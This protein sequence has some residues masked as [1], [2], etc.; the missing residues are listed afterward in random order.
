M[1]MF[2][3]KTSKIPI[4]VIGVGTMGQHHA[5]IISQT[6]GVTLS[7]IFDANP[8]RACEISGR[9]NC[10]VFESLNQALECSRAVCVAAPTTTHLE[11]GRECLGR[12]LHVLMEK[13][14]AD[15]VAGAAE[16]ARLGEKHGVTLMAG[17]VERYNPAIMKMMETLADA[18]EEIISIDIRRLA[19]FDGSR[20]MDVDV[21]YDLMIHDIDLALDLAK[22][23]IKEVHATARPVFSHKNDVA[24]TL[25]EFENGITATLW[26]GKCSPRKLREITVCTRTRQLVADTLNKKLRLHV[27]EELNLQ[28]DGVC[29]MAGIREKE[30]PVPDVEPLRAELED[31]IS[32]I[33]DSRAPVVNGQRALLAMEALEM[34]ASKLG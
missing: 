17:H 29:F 23:T 16:L 34:V 12:G 20:C 3:N 25:I 30:I 7:G 5:R 6:P 14:I 31:F 28:A 10:R 2:M 15:S 22:S 1:F 33:C 18:G 13:P 11:I 27:A 9:H 32:A 24:H 4:G 8:E 26:T 19:P 21:L